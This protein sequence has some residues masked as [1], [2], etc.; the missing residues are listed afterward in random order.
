MIDTTDRHPSTTAVAQ[1]LDTEH[2]PEH[3]AAVAR[4]FETLAAGLLEQ[5][6]DSP[7]LTVALRHLLDAKTA[8]VRCAV[9]G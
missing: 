7:E 9:A 6:P 8:A 3:L 2:L 1:W 5:V 4:P